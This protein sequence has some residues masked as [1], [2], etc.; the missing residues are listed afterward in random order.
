MKTSDIYDL[1]IWRHLYF[2]KLCPSS[3]KY[4][5]KLLQMQNLLFA[6]LSLPWLR[7]LCTCH[8]NCTSP[9]WPSLSPL[10]ALLFSTYLTPPGTHT[11][12]RTHAR[13]WFHSSVFCLTPPTL[14]KDLWGQDFLFIHCSVPS[15][16]SSVRHAHKFTCWIK[17]W[18][19]WTS[20]SSLNILYITHFLFGLIRRLYDYTKNP[21]W[22][23]TIHCMTF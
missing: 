21:K 12:M 23:V 4:E 14:L 13:C 20:G 6:Q 2:Y 18:I 1:Y 7:P 17:E 10:P 11:H 19:I 5:T 22:G 9:P 16:W 3:R 8:N 15:A